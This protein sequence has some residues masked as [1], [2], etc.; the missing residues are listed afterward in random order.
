MPSKALLDLLASDTAVIATTEMAKLRDLPALKT[1]GGLQNDQLI[2]INSQIY[3]GLIKWFDKS[4]GKNEVGA[5][6]ASI[7]KTLCT[8]GIPVSESIYFL[9]VSRK[10]LVDHF[11]RDSMMENSLELYSILQTVDQISDFYALGSYYLTKGYLEDT[12]KAL[13]K[14]AAIPESELR[15]Y[16]KDDFFFK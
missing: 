6:F 7:G 11:Q 9:V 4:G 14:N 5:T 16:F 12:F 10:S 13:A 2:D 15:K 8:A 3:R 1:L